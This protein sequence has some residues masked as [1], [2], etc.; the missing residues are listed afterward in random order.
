MAGNKKPNR[1]P[2]NRASVIERM[3]LGIYAKAKNIAQRETLLI[4]MRNA[5]PMGHEVNQHKIDLTFGAIEGYLAEQEKTG[6]SLVNE[7]GE[8]VVVDPVDGELI[9]AGRA[10]KNQH[11][12]FSALAEAH[13]WGAVPGG[14][15]RMGAKLEADMILFESD[16]FD[17][18]RALA[19]MREHIVEITPNQW[20]ETLDRLIEQ[21][22]LE[23]EKKIDG[24]R[25]AA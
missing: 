3:D 6:E 23:A 18:R 4:R 20:S 21:E 8:P 13:G 12:M 15:R 14:L 10:F 7:R 1:K 19:W 11:A 16:M 24:E 2:G 17:A 5:M 25:R 9:P 22:K